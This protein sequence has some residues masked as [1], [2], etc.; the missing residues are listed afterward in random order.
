MYRDEKLKALYRADSIEKN[1]IAEFRHPGDEV[2]FLTIYDG[3]RFMDMI[4]EESLSSNQNLEFGSCEATQVK[5]TVIGREDGIKD[6][7]MTL[8]Q[9]LDGIYP[10]DDLYPSD[11]LY[12][13]GYVMP[14]GKYVIKSVEQQANM[15]YWDITA[16]DLMCKFDVNVIDWYNALP[17]PLTLRDF[18]ARLCQH[19]GVKEYVPDYLPNDGMMVEKTIETAQLMGWD[20]LIACEQA[21]GA[22]GHFDR[23]GVLQHIVLQPNDGL[24]PSDNLYPADDL[25]PELSGSINTQVYDEQ[26]DPYLMIS[27]R[28]EDYTVRGIEKVQ[29]RQEEGDIGA[30]YGDGENC[31]TV[32][33]N[34]LL[35]GKGA[36]ELHNIARGIYG[37]VGGRMY[38][39]YECNLKGLPYMEVGDAERLDSGGDSIVSYIIKRTLKGI[40]ALKDV[41]SATGEEIRS[42]ESN[43]NTEIIQLK[44][45]AAILK[46]NVEEVSAEL[47]DLEKNTASKFAITA[48]QISA[49]VKRAQAAEASLKIMADNIT[50][51]V[52]ELRNNME[53]QFIQTASQIA[54]KVSKGDV[55]SQISVESGGIDIQGNRFSWTSEYSSMTSEGILSAVD[56]NF[57]GDIE[58]RSFKTTDG[59]ITLL[60][61][62]LTIT[63][64]TINGT[65]NTSNIGCRLLS[66]SYADVSE[67][68]VSG[69]SNLADVGANTIR[70]GKLYGEVNPF[71][72]RRLKH[73]ISNISSNDAIDIIRDLR[74]VS[75]TYNNNGLE[76]MGFIA[77][78]VEDICKKHNLDLPLFRNDDEYYTIPY[79]NYI[80]LIVSVLQ[81]LLEKNKEQ[82]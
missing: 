70:C 10:S 73:D 37:M 64:A 25:Y 50:M 48:E 41:H 68:T 75:F 53:S 15:H 32:E 57:S 39:P 19:I 40:F 4:M 7:E 38:V 17:F 8:Y 30:I 81:K 77:Q 16:L 55:S 63:G 44:G 34:F 49:E 2:P 65:T 31:M 76:S 54:L 69:Y 6:S 60:D 11:G 27:C 45:K 21:N 24:Y 12:P 61:G 5:L 33:G 26:I 62:K 1:L 9:T 36:G 3:E 46:R 43:I 22:F 56:G 18:R 74:P 67:L 52:K 28:F 14:L 29:I 23:I 78:E 47:V 42:A 20:V 59:K 79:L 51:S 82:R 80:P 71:S 58:A 13:S 35:F 66:A 72:D